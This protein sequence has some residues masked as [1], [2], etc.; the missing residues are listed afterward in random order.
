MGESPARPGR[1]FLG[2]GATSRG[3]GTYTILIP[4]ARVGS[5]PV[6]VT[7]RL[8]GFKSQSTQVSLSGGSQTA[9][10][11]LADNPLQLGEIVVTGAGTE[12]AVEK[13]GTVRNNVDSTGEGAQRGG[14]LE[15][16]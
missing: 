11:A 1:R 12:S 9:D 8:I 3:D 13:L 5:Q 16:R 10:F 7:A 4:A 2:L 14:D 6:T 15:L